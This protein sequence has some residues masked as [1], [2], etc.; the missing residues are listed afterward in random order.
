MPVSESQNA[1]TP[2]PGLRSLTGQGRRAFR[3]AALALLSAALAL[4]ARYLPASSPAE[5][6]AVIRQRRTLGAG[7]DAAAVIEQIAS[8]ILSPASLKAALRDVNSSPQPEESLAAAAESLRTRLR[9]EVQPGA[10]R[11][12][13]LIS[14]G[15][16][17]GERNDLDAQI[18]NRLAE[19]YAQASEA[20]DLAGR[21]Q[22]YEAALAACRRGEQFAERSRRDLDRQ[23]DRLAQLAAASQHS[24]ATPPDRAARTRVATRSSE[25]EAKRAE[26]ASQL[27]DL[28]A[29]RLA[30]LERLLPA[31]PEVLALDSEIEMLRTQADKLPPASPAPAAEPHLESNGA[32]PAAQESLAD[33]TQRAWSV[34]KSQRTA[35]AEAMSQASQLAAAERLAAE[36]LPPGVRDEIITLSPAA[37]SQSFAAR[38]LRAFTAII[39]SAGL[40]AGWTLGRRREH[41]SDA[42]RDADEL[43]SALGVP[44]VGVLDSR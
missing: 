20:A 5:T 15:C 33:E 39:G 1:L 34:L 7:E 40:L 8:Q 24:A 35:L 31:H 30:M 14:I 26:L 38:N 32:P 17:N 11:Q 44:L 25:H 43:E 21:K 22:S 42:F 36:Q 28:E 12:P 16:S 29:Q 18:V 9:V 4:I 23:I 37:P 19:V 6:V 27:A 10:G 13:W 3:I 2:P 41:S